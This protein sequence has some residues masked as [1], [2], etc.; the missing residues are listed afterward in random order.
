MTATLNPTPYTQQHNINAS[1]ACDEER[2]ETSMS[3]DIMCLCRL[4]CAA[5]LL[6]HQYHA[7]T[8]AEASLYHVAPGVSL[9]QR[10]CATNVLTAPTFH[11]LWLHGTSVHWFFCYAQGLMLHG[12]GRS[13]FRSTVTF[14]LIICSTQGLVLHDVG[15]EDGGSLRPIMHRASLVEMIVP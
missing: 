11:R 8:A 14:I 4:T 10:A 7:L 3:L 5:S 1:A 15:Y 13:P 12:V 9:Q 2:K 6:Q